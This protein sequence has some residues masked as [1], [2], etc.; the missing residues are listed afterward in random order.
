MG[1]GKK[2]KS[3]ISCSVGGEKA[4]FR[5]QF[6]IGCV[7]ITKRMGSKA[8]EATADVWLSWSVLLPESRNPNLG[9]KATEASS[10][11]LHL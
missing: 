4:G 9:I 7:V 6:P 2:G 10:Q 8:Q 3:T 5:I 1:H 11:A